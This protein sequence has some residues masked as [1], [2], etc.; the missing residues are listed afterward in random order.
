MFWPTDYSLVTYLHTHSPTYLLNYL[1]TYLLTY[2]HTYLP[3]K[4]VTLPAP[5]NDHSVLW[6][7]DF[8]EVSQ[9]INWK[10][11]LVSNFC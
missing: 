1:P 2:M 7:G 8:K 6:R 4:T 11:V 3:S 9:N 5:A 10:M